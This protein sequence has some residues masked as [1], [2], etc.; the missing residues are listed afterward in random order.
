[1]EFLV[2][3]IGA[4]IVALL[5]YVAIVMWHDFARGR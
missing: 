1:M 2:I 3:D 4:T 5:G